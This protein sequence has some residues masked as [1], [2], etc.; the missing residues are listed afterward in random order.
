MSQVNAPTDIEG[1]ERCHDTSDTG[2]TRDTGELTY[3]R[4]H[5]AGFISHTLR[6]RRGW[7]GF[8]CTDSLYNQGQLITF[9]GR[10]MCACVLTVSHKVMYK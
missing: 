5:V 1:T 4:S 8:M 10:V 9:C 7:W 3:F 6:K 2:Y